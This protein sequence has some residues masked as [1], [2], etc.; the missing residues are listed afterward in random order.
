MQLIQNYMEDRAKRQALNELTQQVFGF[1]FEGWVTGGY[2][3]GDYIPYSLEE[4][5][6]L[7]A[8]VSVNRM[9]FLQNGE[10]KHYIQLGTVMTRPDCRGKGYARALMERVLEQYRGKCDGIY[11]FGNLDALGFYDRLGFRRGLQYRYTLRQKPERLG[12][13]FRPAEDKARYQALVRASG[14]N[15]ALEQVNKFGLQMFYTAGMEDV[16]YCEE[17]DCHIALERQ[18]GEVCLQSVI[19]PRIIPLAQILQRLPEDYDGLTLGFAPRGEDAYL[20]DA[21]PYDGAGDYRLF[22]MGDDIKSIEAQK[23][24]FPEFSH[25]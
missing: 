15:A 19:C 8:N 6:R 1:D 22:Y 3:E 16:W 4:D 17:L 7:I 24:Y 10:R 20:F 5:G 11:L 9:E 12:S 13:P 2:Y 21:E 25:A 18:G 14:A 23:L